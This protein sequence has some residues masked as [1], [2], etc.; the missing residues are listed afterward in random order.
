[1]KNSNDTLSTLKHELEFLES[2]GYRSAIGS[3]QPLFC[4]ETSVEWRQ[5]LFFEDSPSCPKKKYC[6]CD[7]ESDCVLMSFAPTEYRQQA[8]PCRHIPL[9]EQGQTI[10]GLSSTTTHK[11]L[12]EK[13]HTWL[14]KTIKG[15]EGPIADEMSSS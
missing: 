2:G 12:E 10:D 8:V 1:M 15:F 4:M 13:L 9:D 11:D 14:V 6:A 5:R 3:R 7:P